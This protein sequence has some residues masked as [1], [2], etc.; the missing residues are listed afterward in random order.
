MD[1][2]IK[3]KLWNKLAR[4]MWDIELYNEEYIHDKVIFKKLEEAAN[5]M[6]EINN[7]RT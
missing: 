3:K 4:C 5:I 7:A 1:I 2:K 6:K